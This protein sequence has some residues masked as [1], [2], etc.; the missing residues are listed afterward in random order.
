VEGFSFYKQAARNASAGPNHGGLCAEW[1]GAN[2][3]AKLKTAE[4][5]SNAVYIRLGLNSHIWSIW[6][7]WFALDHAVPGMVAPACPSLHASA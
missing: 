3:S 2:P 1:R 5:V 4:Y 7:Q 6:D